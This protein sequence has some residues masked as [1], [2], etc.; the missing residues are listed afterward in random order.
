MKVEIRGKRDKGLEAIASVLEDYGRDHAEAE[1]TLYRHAPLSVRVRIIDPDFAEMD[2][3]ERNHH[4]W[5]YLGRLSEDDQSDVNVLLL[6]APDEVEKSFGNMEFED[7][8]P[9]IWAEV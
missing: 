7:P 6:L 2:R 4:V 5:D 1:A 8:I 9:S 3:A